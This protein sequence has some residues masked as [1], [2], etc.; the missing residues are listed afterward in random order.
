MEHTQSL[1]DR[2]NQVRRQT[3]RKSG[4]IRSSNILIYLLTHRP[5]LLLTGL[6]TMLLGTAALALYSLGYAGSADNIELIEEIPAVV[7]KPITI[8]SEHS[9]PTPLWLVA[10]IA[11]SCASGCYIIFQLVNRPHNQHPQIRQPIKHDAE[12][13]PKERSY[14]ASKPLKPN[15]SQTWEPA[16]VKNPPVFIPLQP[17]K[18][19]IPR[20]NKSQSPVTVLPPEHQ[21]PLDKRKETLAD[22]MDIRK[23]SSLSTIL[24][25][26]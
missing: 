17:L 10:A 20:G 3:N 24:Q 11:L 22:L 13:S 6:L 15:R 14:R 1:Q 26:Y 12:T 4:L 16:I 9:N 18:Q 2:P 7:E 25:K 5:G 23:H 21:H 8:S 19:I